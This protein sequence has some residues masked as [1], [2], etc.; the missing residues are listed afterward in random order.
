VLAENANCAS[1]RS[2]RAF[3]A[4]WTGEEESVTCTVKFEVAAVVGVPVIAPVLELSVR[5][6]GK[7]P[8][9]IE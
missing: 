7:L 9:L 8:V 4:V 3:V 1:T 2:V 5:P 6:A